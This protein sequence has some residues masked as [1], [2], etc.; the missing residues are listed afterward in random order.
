[1]LHKTDGKMFDKVSDAKVGDYI[2]VVEMLGEPKYRGRKGIVESIDD[3]GQLHGTWG[4]LAVNPLDVII[5]I[6]RKK[7]DK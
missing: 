6:Y 2:E 4:G 5:I 3:Q 7:E 1:M